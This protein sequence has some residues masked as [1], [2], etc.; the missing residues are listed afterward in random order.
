[1]IIFRRN[2]QCDITAER[3]GAEHRWR[4]I[5][6]L[7]VF[8]LARSVP[9]KWDLRLAESAGCR[10][11]ST[12]N[13]E[14]TRKREH[15]QDRKN[16]FEEKNCRWERKSLNFIVYRRLSFSPEFCSEQ[17]IKQQN[18]KPPKSGELFNC[19][20]ENVLLHLFNLN[21][22]APALDW[23]CLAVSRRAPGSQRIKQ[24]HICQEQA[25]RGE[26]R[27]RVPKFLWYGLT[28]KAKNYSRRR[29][30]LCKWVAIAAADINLCHFHSLSKI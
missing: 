28:G 12:G 24:E 15:E 27:N 3:S 30:A 13:G 23:D 10:T 18:I 9:R 21:S 19:W 2:R 6:L 29:F 11:R 22:L 1:M 5:V 17:Q 16:I 26:S 8:C 7:I 20:A 25:G 14:R 4:L